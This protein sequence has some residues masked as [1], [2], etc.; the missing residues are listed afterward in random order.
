MQRL[1][2]RAEAAERLCVALADA[3]QQWI[4]GAPT[5]WREAVEA[6]RRRLEEP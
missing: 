6:M 2:E 4:W 3:H 5:E 1:Q